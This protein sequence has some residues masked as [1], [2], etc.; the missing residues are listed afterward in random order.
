M[1]TALAATMRKILVVSEANNRRDGITGFLLCDGYTFVQ[2]LEGPER[3]VQECFLRICADTRNS[4]PTIRDVG[5]SSAR[6]FPEWSMCALNLS[7][8]DNLLLRPGD[9]GFDL[10]AA[11]PGALRQYLSA[12]ARDHGQDL[13]RAHAPFMNKPTGMV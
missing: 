12:L 2:W 9:I 4:T 1:A 6:L 10:S 5:W 3:S 8:R 13:M 11:S 7:G